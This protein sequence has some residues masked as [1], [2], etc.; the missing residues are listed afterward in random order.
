MVKKKKMAKKKKKY[1]RPEF[2]SWVR[3]I[4]WKRE[5]Q[6]TPVFFPGESHGQSSLVSYRVEHD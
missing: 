2:D 1:R 6:P 3:K 4:P 5:W